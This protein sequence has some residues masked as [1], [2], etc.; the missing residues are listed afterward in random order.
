LQVTI[1]SPIRLDTREVEFFLRIMEFNKKPGKWK[2]IAEAQKAFQ[3]QFK[4]KISRPTIYE[5]IKIY[6]TGHSYL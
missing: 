2:K 3:Q 6:S 1:V 4:R 5:L